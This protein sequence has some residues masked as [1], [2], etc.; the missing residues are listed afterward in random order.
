MQLLTSEGGAEG[1]VRGEK[2]IAVLSLGTGVQSSALAVLAAT[3]KVSPR[4]EAT[5][6]ADTFCEWPETYEFLTTYLRPWLEEHGPL[7]FVVSAGD[8]LQPRLTAPC[9]WQEEA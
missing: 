2:E 5:M 1:R 9:F 6:F 4:P 7:V 8:I 3:G